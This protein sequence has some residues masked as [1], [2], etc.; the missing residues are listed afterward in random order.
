MK[1]VSCLF[2]TKVTK[3]YTFEIYNEIYIKF[4]HLKLQ[5]GSYFSLSFL[6]TQVGGILFHKS[7]NKGFFSWRCCVIMIRNCLGV[8][9][10]TENFSKN[11]HWGCP[12]KSRFLRQHF[13]TFRR[14][15]LTFRWYVFTASIYSNYFCVFYDLEAGVETWQL[16][17]KAILFEWFLCRLQ[18]S[19]ECLMGVLGLNVLQVLNFL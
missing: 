4:K 11:F 7:C 5:N 8:K 1:N 6:L 12:L 10:S 9:N 16:T 19:G 3:I 2:K 13:Y 17:C 15:K 14:S 18:G